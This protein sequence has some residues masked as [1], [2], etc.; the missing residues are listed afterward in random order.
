MEDEEYIYPSTSGYTVYSKSGCSNCIKT[1]IYLSSN[2]VKML[3]INCDEY[4]IDNKENFLQFIAKLAEKEVKIFPM[5]F[6]ESQFIGGYNE[7]M[8]HNEREVAFLNENF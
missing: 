8:I 5:I 7:V 6:Y 3:Y 2:G 1:K 4:I